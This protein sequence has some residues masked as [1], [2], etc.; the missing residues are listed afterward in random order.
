MVATKKENVAGLFYPES[1]KELESFFDV[2]FSG[3]AVDSDFDMRK[4]KGII[5]PHAGYEYSGRGAYLAHSLLAQ[6]NFS[7]LI[8]VGPSHY[9]PFRGVALPPWDSFSTPLG[10]LQVDKEAIERLADLPEVHID[11]APF[12]REHSLE[13]QLPFTVHFTPQ[14]KV[15]PALTGVVAPE[16]SARIFSTFWDDEDTGFIVSSDLSHFNNYKTATELDAETA[17]LIEQ[18]KYDMLSGDRA[19][20][21]HALGGLLFEAQKRGAEIERL[22]LFNSGDATGNKKRVV[23]YGAWAI[24]DG[25]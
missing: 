3:K 1:R 4:L 15:V 5:S 2:Q 7:R 9:V 6:K 12:E 13:V 16:E 18:K 22:A 11:A 17:G 24:V 8:I 21:Y 23:G 20:G 10:E 25:K 19:C 14:A